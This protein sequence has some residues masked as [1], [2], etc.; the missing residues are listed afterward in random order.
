SDGWGPGR[1]EDVGMAED[2]EGVHAMRPAGDRGG[3]YRLPSVAEGAL[4]IARQVACKL[5]CLVSQYQHLGVLAPARDLD[6]PPRGRR[7]LSEP[8]EPGE[9]ERPSGQARF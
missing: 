6:G 7:G 8:T 5:A 1:G 4:H 2:G 9:R 3:R